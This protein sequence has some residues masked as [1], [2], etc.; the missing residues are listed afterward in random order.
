[1]RRIKIK[2]GDEGR[3]DGVAVSRKRINGTEK[4]EN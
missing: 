2:E 3:D 4:T 1:M